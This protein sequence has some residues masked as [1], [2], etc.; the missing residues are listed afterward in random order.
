MIRDDEYTIEPKK[1]KSVFGRRN[2]KF[3]EILNSKNF[4]YFN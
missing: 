2:L 3:S 4:K 1:T